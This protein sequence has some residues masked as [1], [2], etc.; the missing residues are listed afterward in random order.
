MSIFANSRRTGNRRATG[1]GGS[2]PVYSTL[3]ARST[4]FSYSASSIVQNTGS[5]IGVNAHNARH[6]KSGY[7][8]LGCSATD[9]A[10]SY[11]AACAYMKSQNPNVKILHYVIQTE[12]VGYNELSNSTNQAAMLALGALLNEV[13][14]RTDT[15]TYWQCNTAPGDT[16]GKWTNTGSANYPAYTDTGFL[17]E[18]GGRYAKMQSM[19]GWM[20]RRSAANGRIRMQQYAG[21]NLNQIG[22]TTRATDGSGRTLQKWVAELYYKPG[23]G[24]HVQSTLGNYI[25]GIWMDNTKIYP[26]YW[27]LDLEDSGV[28][29]AGSPP[30]ATRRNWAILGHGRFIDELR[31][32]RPTALI[33]GNSQCNDPQTQT[34]QFYSTPQLQ[35][36]DGGMYE[37]AGSFSGNINIKTLHGQGWAK[38]M[39]VYQS[40]TNLLTGPNKA[41]ALTIGLST[42]TAFAEARLGICSALLGD[43]Q[44]NL[45]VGD[46]LTATP[47]DFD[48][49]NANLGTPIDPMPTVATTGNLWKRRYQNGVVIFNGATV[50]GAG[51]PNWTSGAAET[52]NTSLIPYNVYKR[53]AGSMDPSTN[54]GSIVSGS[55]SLN[56]WDGRVLLCVAAGVHS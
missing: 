10:S 23:A 52:V 40:L 47:P 16:L 6:A 20:L 39:T 46:S 1:S 14:Y 7:V 50:V 21:T 33:H 34:A 48:E 12:T 55:F 32:I 29:D 18:G 35:G 41:V 26:S 25:D 42:D 8:V 43:G 54:N 5:G 4:T 37:F 11:A 49:Y 19:P 30:T 2:P 36:L 51:P 38:M 27:S 3:H 31:A 15:S 45:L 44:I 24:L 53:I 56:G 13:T 28:E 9:T 22:A 17:F